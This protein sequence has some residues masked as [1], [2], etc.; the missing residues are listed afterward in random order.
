MHCTNVQND[1]SFKSQA[2][3]LPASQPLSGQFLLSCDGRWHGWKKM[4]RT[5]PGERHGCRHALLGDPR[6]DVYFAVT[7][8]KWVFQCRHSIGFILASWLHFNQPTSRNPWNSLSVLGHVESLTVWDL[9]MTSSCSPGVFQ[10]LGKP[11]GIWYNRCLC[12]EIYHIYHSTAW[13]AS[14]SC[15]WGAAV[16]STTVRAESSMGIRLGFFA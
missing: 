7:S 10:S 12:W 2:H 14:T 13:M 8:D 15:C 5:C 6:H 4:V 16:L 11:S 1:W 9:G 3:N